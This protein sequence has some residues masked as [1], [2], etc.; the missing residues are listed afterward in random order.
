MDYNK[1][2]QGASIL[3]VAVGQLN[4]DD[5][6][7]FEEVDQFLEEIAT[8]VRDE[9]EHDEAV[10]SPG[11]GDEVL[12]EVEEVQ[13]GRGRPHLP[14]EVHLDQEIGGRDEETVKHRSLGRRSVESEQ[15]LQSRVR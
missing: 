11:Q 3:V 1:G 10:G 8:H 4:F 7:L 14:D 2:G 5:V 6:G 15:S 12:S 9:H 13:L